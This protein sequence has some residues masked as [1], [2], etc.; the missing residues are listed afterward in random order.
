MGRKVLW[1]FAL[2]TLLWML[3]PVSA[4]T[5]ISNNAADMASH[6]VMVADSSI[7][8][9]VTN[10]FTFDRGASAPFAVGASST[11]VTNLDADKLDGNDSTAFLTT[12]S[13][14]NA[15]NMTTGTLP[16][17][18]I[19]G[20]TFKAADGTVS[21]PGLTFNAD[22][23]NGFYRIGTNS[24]G[25]ATNGVLALSVDAN[26]FITSA[27]QPRASAYNNTTQSINSGSDTALTFNSED[28]DV[29]SMHST[30]ANTS[31]I[32]VPTGGDGL[33]VVTAQTL[34]ENA[35]D[36]SCVLKLKKNGTTEFGSGDSRPSA[37][38]NGSA[39]ATAWVTLAA[40]DY[41]EVLVNQ[42]SG[43]ARNVGSASRGPASALQ[44]IRIW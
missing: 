40:A 31:R 30:S 15:T 26:Q 32:T 8:R 13:A 25:W 43:S 6:I 11:K 19:D 9:T 37:S 7:P 29:G 41:V 21:A 16:S 1:G 22:S 12:S 23:D 33:Y 38:L 4:Q 2:L 5:V 14:L 35:S 44:V 18:R 39:K 10:L 34:C 3:I 28:W 20:G 36:Y 24:V 17:A 27:T 42:N